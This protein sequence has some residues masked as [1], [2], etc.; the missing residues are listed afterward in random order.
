MKM[1]LELYPSKLRSIS[2][3]EIIGNCYFLFFV[4]LNTFQTFYNKMAVNYY[5]IIL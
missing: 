5:N 1:D 2:E 4:L 3:N